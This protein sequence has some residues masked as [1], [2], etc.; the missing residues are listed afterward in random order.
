MVEGTSDSH[1]QLPMACGDKDND[2][3]PEFNDCGKLK[4]KNSKPAEPQKIYW[5][6]SFFMHGQVGQ[7][8]THC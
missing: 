5:L 6:R 1:S 8:F 2:Y 4:R 7:Y 3:I